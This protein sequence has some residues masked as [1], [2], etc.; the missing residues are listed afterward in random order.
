MTAS[1]APSV[2]RRAGDARTPRV[3]E[4]VLFEPT[5]AAFG[6]IAVLFAVLDVARIQVPYPVQVVPFAISVLVFGLPHGALDHLVPARLDSAISVRRSIATVVALYA[7]LGG[8][9]AL[10]WGLDPVVGFVAFI[11]VTWFHWGQGDL[12]LDRA[13][14]HAVDSRAD[15][16]LTVL[17]RGA[18]PMLLP[19]ITHPLDYAGVFRATT[20]LIDPAA[21]GAD[22]LD[23]VPIRFAAAVLLVVL[24][25]AHALVRHRL[26]NPMGTTMAEVVVLVAFFSAVPPVLA[27]GVYFTFWHAVRHIVRLELLEPDGAAGLARGDLLRP[28]GRFLRDALPVTLCAIALLAVLALSLRSAGLGT[29]LLLIAALTTP[30]TAVV[31]WM[32]RRRVRRGGADLR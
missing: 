12:W 20:R 11:A 17:T 14:G 7:V 3:L 8:A 26:G 22:L 28:F 2:D 32:D 27:V 9:T 15:A 18:L 24:I 1:A 30:H 4:R 25:A 31:A 5:T 21:A 29:Y 10:L 6:A 23:A 16:V 13:R 19:L